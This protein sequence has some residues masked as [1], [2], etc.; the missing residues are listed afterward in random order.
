MAYADTAGAIGSLYRLS[1]TGTVDRMLTGVGISN[2]LGWSA[3][4]RTFF[5]TDT[6]TQGVDAFDYDA[7]SGEIRD[8]RRVIT[9]AAA[10][11]VPDGLAID[12]AGCFWV[13]VWGGGEVR[14]YTPDGVLDRTISLPVT[15][16][17]SCAF[18]GD[19]LDTMFITTARWGLDAQELERQPLAGAVFA[20]DPGT[21]GV[22]DHQFAG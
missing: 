5:Y 19:R 15:N 20:A 8:R 13:A 10:D 3:D 11:G 1:A 6:P 18:G 21:T 12:A 2:G 14:R 16:V 17:T 22:L 7:D 9:I 4:E